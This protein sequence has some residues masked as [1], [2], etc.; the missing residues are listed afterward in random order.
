MLAHK[1]DAY[2]IKLTLRPRTGLGPF[3]MW[4]L[5]CECSA[6]VEF[7]IPLDDEFRLG[8]WLEDLKHAPDCYIRRRKVTEK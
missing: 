3:K 1:I 7:S 4:A 2:K 5:C 6:L 8:P